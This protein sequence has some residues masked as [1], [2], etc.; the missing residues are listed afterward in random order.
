[1][2]EL[3]STRRNLE[4]DE[5]EELVSTYRLFLE[6]RYLETK[7]IF[8]LVLRTFLDK[9]KITIEN[10]PRYALMST[11][12]N[13]IIVNKIY[14]SK[15]KSNKPL[16]FILI[17]HELL[18]QILLHDKKIHVV[19]NPILYN[20]VADAYV[21]ELIKRKLKLKIPKTLITYSNIIDALYKLGIRSVD[22]RKV[23]EEVIRTIEEISVDTA[24][25]TLLSILKKNPE[26][27]EKFLRNFSKG[28]FNGKDLQ[29]QTGEKTCEK[30]SLKPKNI[31]KFIKELRRA[32]EQV[33]ENINEAKGIAEALDNRL[34]NGD[35]DY[36]EKMERMAGRGTGYEEI[37]SLREIR[38][39]KVM[40]RK[41]EDI[42]DA[43]V[44]KKLGEGKYSFE[45]YDSS[46]YWLP[47]RY[48]EQ[49]EKIYVFLDTSGSLSSNE[50]KLLLGIL[51]S[52]ITKYDIHESKLA[53]FSEDVYSTEEL[54][55]VADVE[56]KT[57]RGG[58]FLGR[59]AYKI[60]M[61]ARR[62]M[63][64]VIVMSDF[65]INYDYRVRNLLR[66]IKPICINVT[67]R[68]PGYCGEKIRAPRIP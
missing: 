40:I 52:I 24:Y 13:M 12:N 57:D 14:Y 46:V 23:E 45:S 44:S 15:I 51:K 29:V 62:E 50:I 5:L 34:D 61:K 30:Q 27:A 2:Q 39:I 47:D 18:H 64:P 32:A 48:A 8:F 21:N 41:L 22:I 9:S 66:D 67:D 42:I 26:K 3:S 60:L 37:F 17:T 43:S 25:N 35:L 7:N 19:E 38:E 68:F 54:R 58:T 53:L 56:L 10:L 16:F 36:R 55:N 4:K 11:S 33:I 1:M 49:V 31:N 6:K 20:I 65:G 59:K 28:L 63:A